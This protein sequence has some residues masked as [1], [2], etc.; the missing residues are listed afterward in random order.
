MFG[1][2]KRYDVHLCPE[3]RGIISNNGE[4]LAGLRVYRELDYDRAYSDSAITDAQGRFFFA[5]KN[6]RSCLP[7]NMLDQS[8]VRQVLSV[9]YQQ[10]TY[11]L[12]YSSTPSLQPHS[13]FQQALSDLQCEL[14]SP[15]QHMVFANE[16]Y[17]DH[18][19]GVVGICKPA[20][21]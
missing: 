21:P 6:I 5:E 3:V 2:L 13:A 8:T 15:E 16:E 20:S 1:W 7:G 17:P 12:W 19:L 4:P 11:L 10:K 9:D 18:P 14:S